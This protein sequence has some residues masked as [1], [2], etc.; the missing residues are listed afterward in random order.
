MKHILIGSLLLASGPTFAN[1]WTMCEQQ[2]PTCEGGAQPSPVPADLTGVTVHN[3]CNGC[4]PQQRRT[5]AEGDAE[6]TGLAYAHMLGNW[7]QRYHALMREIDTT[8]ELLNLEIEEPTCQPEQILAAANATKGTENCKSSFASITDAV[9]AASVSLRSSHAPVADYLRMLGTALSEGIIPD[10]SLGEMYFTEEGGQAP[11]CVGVDQLALTSSVAPRIGLSVLA[12]GNAPDE[13]LDNFFEDNPDLFGFSMETMPARGS[14][15][16]TL[17]H[18]RI[19]SRVGIFRGDSSV[20]GSDA[21]ST[22][23]QD[24]ITQAATLRGHAASACSP[25]AVERNQ[26]ISSLPRIFPTAQLLARLASAQ[27]ALELTPEDCSKV[28]AV[29]DAHIQ[30]F[31]RV[32]QRLGRERDTAQIYRSAYQELARNS[33]EQFRNW[34]RGSA[35]RD[36]LRSYAAASC[37]RLSEEMA[38][39]VCQA[40]GPITNPEI[41]Y[42]AYQQFG[43]NGCGVEPPLLPT[44]GLLAVPQGMFGYSAEA[45]QTR[46]LLDELNRSSCGAEGRRVAA[47]CDGLNPGATAEARMTC[48][49][50]NVNSNC[51]EA[52]SRNQLRCLLGSAT[53][54]VL[55]PSMARVRERRPESGTGFA[56]IYAYEPSVRAV[57]R[58]KAFSM[59]PKGALM[60]SQAAQSA[61][62]QGG[63]GGQAP[64][65]VE[66]Q[67]GPAAPSFTPANA[68]ATIT[69]VGSTIQSLQEVARA[70]ELQQPRDPGNLSQTSTYDNLLRQYQDLERRFAAVQSEAQRIPVEER[71]AVRAALPT[72]QEQEMFDALVSPSAYSVPSSMSRYE[73]SELMNQPGSSNPLQPAALP[74]VVADIVAQSTRPGAAATEPR[75]TLNT[76]SGPQA[77]DSFPVPSEVEGREELEAYLAEQA[78]NGDLLGSR[79]SR[80]VS[81]RGKLW[82]VRRDGNN[83]VVTEVTETATRQALV[84]F[85]RAS[86]HHFVSQLPNTDF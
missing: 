81:V 82:E 68:A 10:S 43:V 8:S 60:A 62:S 73:P 25:N 52:E 51:N 64:T 19:D 35:L 83:I 78:R 22:V 80:V 53:N 54:R 29:F 57:A 77:V 9:N 33:R 50:S 23:I 7:F 28:R 67:R 4:H 27:S 66:T 5:S 6:R 16:R 3:I 38:Q 2:P 13:S 65:V 76:E 69:S 15:S 71:P 11:R 59:T 21:N 20:A 37:R 47:H 70:P 18:I 41:V 75:L 44:T 45:A 40:G 48:L 63:Q 31:Q 56:N 72:T 26:A 46:H 39:G 42:S 74:T 30:F 58:A 34:R 36:T 32:G 79:R 61:P 49:I 12:Q 14:L 24:A 1:N 86:Y 85:Q 17:N 55:P 84:D